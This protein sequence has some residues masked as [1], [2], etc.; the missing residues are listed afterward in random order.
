MTSEEKKAILLEYRRLDARINRAIAEQQRWRDLAIRITPVYS[1]MPRGGGSGDK[2]LDA[3]QHI[4]DME[5][6]IDRE[7]DRLVSLRQTIEASIA[8]VQD[9]RLRDILRRRY[10]DGDRMERI[11]VDLCLDYRWV[12][13][14]HARA[15]ARLTLESPPKS[16]L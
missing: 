1:G 5:A 3:V 10:I 6:D 13:R 7:I 14:L 15:L 2:L 11:A 12:R 4:A 16:V 8:A 9:E